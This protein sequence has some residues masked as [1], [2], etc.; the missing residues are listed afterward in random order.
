MRRTRG[1]RDATLACQTDTTTNKDK[2]PNCVL[3]VLKARS[4][5]TPPAGWTLRRRASSTRLR[6]RR[7]RHP[8][9]EPFRDRLDTW[10]PVIHTS[11]VLCAGPI[12]DLWTRNHCVL[13]RGI[14]V[15][16]LPALA[17]RR[18]TTCLLVQTTDPDGVLFFVS[19]GLA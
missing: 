10:L 16:V 14:Y 12:R 9:R 3:Y 2:P 4:T 17:N 18:R 19:Y 8:F 7:R 6:L 5:G 15:Y 11:C 1:Y 13:L